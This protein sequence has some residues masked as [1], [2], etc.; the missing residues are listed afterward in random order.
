M[1]LIFRGDMDELK[2]GLERMSRHLSFHYSLNTVTTPLSGACYIEVEQWNDGIEVEQNSDGSGTIRYEKQVHFFRALGL[3]LQNAESQKPFRVRE[4]PQFDECGA[5]FDVSRNAVVK[6]DALKKMLRI[7]ASMGFTQIMLYTEDTYSVE[8]EPY[9]GYMRGHYGTEELKDLDDYAHH[10][11]IEMVPCIQTL[12]HLETFLRWNTSAKY[13]DT[14]DILLADSPDVHQL[15]E[16]MIDTI[17]Q[18][19]RSRRIHLG[20]DEAHDI[21]RGTY[22]DT[23]GYKRRFDIMTGHL[24]QV[25]EIAESRGFRP[26][27]WSDM[28]F[29]LGSPT[30]DYYD[31]SA[32]IPEDVKRAIRPDIQLV[33]WDYYHNDELDYRSLI[34][35]HQKLGSNPIFAGGVWTFSGM[36]THYHKTFLTS[37]AALSACKKEGVKEVFTTVWLDNGAENHIFSSLLG[38]QL[39]AEHTYDPGPEPEKLE[40]RF[41]YCVG[42][43]AGAFQDLSLLD[44]TPGANKELNE[45]DNPSKYLLWQDVL[46]GLFDKQIED[47]DLASHYTEVYKLLSKHEEAY[48]NLDYVFEIPCKLASVLQLKCDLGI[49][50]KACYDKLDKVDMQYFTQ[51]ELPELRDRVLE[52]RIAHRKHWF[53]IH[54]PFGWEVLDIR[55]GGLLARLDTAM[56]RLSQWT[57]GSVPC[58]EELEEERLWFD[59]RPRTASNGIGRMNRYHRIVTTGTL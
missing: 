35:A 5:M 9:F 52:L 28:F 47:Y 58:L 48:P 59:G 31:P 55:Y 53:A 24:N 6:P 45:P 34:Q 32:V 30:G 27:I 57:N 51:M 25:V 39:Y 20:M 38:L 4:K 49:R 1:H 40:E 33:Y 44:A 8:S 18:T 21:G 12:A 43:E 29:R 50:I 36:A 2:I 7:M 10:L 26:M 16:A 13:R 46:L 19:F 17:S 11:G 41:L 15:I 23:F 22:L 42:A 54:K 56:E 3:Y 14:P 37:N